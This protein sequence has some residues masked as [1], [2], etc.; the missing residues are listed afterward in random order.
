MKVKHVEMALRLRTTD[1]L[2]EV[3]RPLVVLLFVI[4]CPKSQS[5]FNILGW[6]IFSVQQF[7]KVAS[8]SVY[9][10]YMWHAQRKTVVKLQGF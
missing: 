5:Y 2:Q 3:T 7:N 9:I 10:H 6:A 4:C 8:K 1:D